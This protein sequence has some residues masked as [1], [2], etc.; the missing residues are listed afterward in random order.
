MVERL[1]CSL[2]Q[3]LRTFVEKQDDWERYLPLILYAYRTAV[4]SLTGV[5]P[6]TLMYGRQPLT[7][8]FSPD[9]TFYTASYPV[10][11]QAKFSELQDLMDTNLAAAGDHQKSA[12]DQHTAV[13]TFNLN[14]PVWLSVPTAGKLDPRWEGGWR[15]KSTNSPVT[16]ETTDGQRMKVIHVI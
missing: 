12:Y 13:H 1:N 9:A 7:P 16:F 8:D 6:F 14:D 5:S 11:L 3:L 15:M 2:L 10:H 4:H